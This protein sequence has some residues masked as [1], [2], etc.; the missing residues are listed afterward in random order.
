M[1]VC[2]Y[3]VLSRNEEASELLPATYST[4]GYEEKSYIKFSIKAKLDRDV[5]IPSDLFTDDPDITCEETLAGYSDEDILYLISEYLEDDS[6]RSFEVDA[7]QYYDEDGFFCDWDSY[8]CEDDDE[9]E[10]DE[11]DE[12]DDDDSYDDE[13]EVEE[14]SATPTTR[15]NWLDKFKFWK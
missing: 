10:Y 8:E 9:D 14:L 11:D 1:R 13:D 5:Y 12:E 2:K 3:V 7:T 15:D 6:V 4:E